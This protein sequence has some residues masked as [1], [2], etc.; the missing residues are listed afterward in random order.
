MNIFLILFLAGTALGVIADILLE[1]I[2]FNFRKKHGKKIPEEVRGC[3]DEAT[4]GKTVLYRNAGYSSDGKTAYYC[5]LKD[6]NWK[7]V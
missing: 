6:V 1:T 7:K 3:L 2:D 5:L 4:A